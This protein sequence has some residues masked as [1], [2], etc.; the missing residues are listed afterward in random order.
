MST[1]AHYIISLLETTLATRLFMATSINPFLAE[2]RVSVYYAYSKAE[3]QPPEICIY[4]VF[5]LP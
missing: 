4:I 5:M 2:K 3:A 1:R